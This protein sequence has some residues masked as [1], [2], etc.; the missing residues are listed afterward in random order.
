MSATVL[1]L[2]LAVFIAWRVVIGWRMGGAIAILRLAGL[3]AG[4]LAG[5]WAAPRVLAWMKLSSTGSALNTIV[6]I[7]LVLI[8]SAVGEAV[9]GGLGRAI[10]RG[11]SGSGVIRGIDG[12]LGALA[13]LL[14]VSFLVWFVGA[15]VRPVL[16]ESWAR[17]VNASRVL[18]TLD[19]L[20][21]DA[22]RP[23]PSRVT[24]VLRDSGFPRVFGGLQPEPE[25]PADEPD[26]AVTRSAGVQAAA[27][28]IVKIVSDAPT[29]SSDSAGSG[30]VVSAQRVVTNAHVVAGSAQ[31]SVQV[32]GQGTRYSSEVVAFDAELDLAIL[33]VPQ[34]A[35]PAL[36]RETSSLA[37]QD[38]VVA[39][40]FP[41]GGPYTLKAGRIRGVI[42]ATGEDIYGDQSVTRQ[43]YSVRT[44]VLPGNSGGPLL[45]PEG[46]VA[47]TVFA[48]S[49][50]DPETGF[51]LTDAATE[52]MLAGAESYRTEVST[53]ACAG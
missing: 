21:P 20:V 32:G 47:G 53:G 49:L 3:L 7:L 4:V 1:D 50:T 38:D 25:L 35:A 33:A 12:L 9:F 11:I 28:S 18:T 48:K 23:W 27:A 36:V 15:A 6:I 34:L 26:S 8:G 46:E 43:V 41:L 44:T 40:G 14:V 51:A 19:A 45:T 37:A 31:V 52:A 30:W 22:A 13:Y 42:Q 17:T 24:K 29:C 10:R 5:L 16:P 39:A 2:I